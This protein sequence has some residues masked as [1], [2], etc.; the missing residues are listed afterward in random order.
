[1]KGE[2]LEAFDTYLRS[3]GYSSNTISSYQFAASQ[4]N[5]RLPSLNDQAL[6]DH[7]DWLVSTFSAKTANN[8]IGAINVYLDYL[9]YEGIRI[10]GVKVQQKPFLDNVI[11]KKEYQTLIRGLK[12]DDDLFWYFAIRYLAC[13][14]ARVSELR[15]FEVK[16]AELGYMDLISKGNKLRRVYIPKPLRNETLTW[17]NQSNKTSG[18][19]F[20]SEKGKALSTRGI[21]LGLKRAALRYGVNQ[22]VVYPHSFRHLFAKSFIERN[23]DIAFLADLMGHESIETTRIYLRRT[24]SEQIATVDRTV[25]W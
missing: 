19:L 18:L 13:T 17:C 24:A 6:L 2:A 4:L 25:N 15:C 10:K 11:S 3:H 7:K 21:S 16:H 9:G 8:R 5:E 20:C 1:M 23:P 12:D 22:D 14:G